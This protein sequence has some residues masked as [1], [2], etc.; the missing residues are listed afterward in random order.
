MSS[1]RSILATRQSQSSPNSTRPA[2]HGQLK[3]E[4]IRSSNERMVEE[5]ILHPI[6]MDFETTLRA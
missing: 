6:N 1:E 5:V 2:S 3:P 4:P